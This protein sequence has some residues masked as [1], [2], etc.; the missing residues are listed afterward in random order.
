MYLQCC[1]GTTFL[2]Y[3]AECC[4]YAAFSLNIYY[5]S[6][7]YFT[8]HI[9]TDM[10]SLIH[11]VYVTYDIYVGCKWWL[12]YFWCINVTDLPHSI[13]FGAA[14]I[15]CTLLIGC[16]ISC[17]VLIGCSIAASSH[18]YIRRE[19]M[20]NNQLHFWQHPTRQI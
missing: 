20:R 15:S 5:K 12:V 7:S 14:C 4:S 1:I 18:G 16:S 19:S 3:F 13:L 17:T 8:V 10:N 11:L 2:C 9:V 6:Y